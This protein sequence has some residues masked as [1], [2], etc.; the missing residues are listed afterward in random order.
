[1]VRALRHGSLADGGGGGAAY[2]NAYVRFCAISDQR[3]RTNCFANLDDDALD[4]DIERV[5]C[6]ESGHDLPQGQAWG[7]V[8]LRC[9]RKLRTRSRAGPASG[10]EARDA[11]AAIHSNYFER[12]RWRRSHRGTFRQ[13]FAG[14]YLPRA[15]RRTPGTKNTWR[16]FS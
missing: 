1:M 13:G 7:L 9:Q 5:R 16:R 11:Q 14:A 10:R 8:L 6:R 2:Y 15:I 4:A 12:K 3:P